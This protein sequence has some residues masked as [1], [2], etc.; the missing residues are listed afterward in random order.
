MPTLQSMLVYDGAFH[1]V[2]LIHNA[3]PELTTH[4]S[5]ILYVKAHHE[6]LAKRFI[7][8]V[9]VRLVFDVTGE[10]IERVEVVDDTGSL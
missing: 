10:R 3:D 4:A 8:R 7:H 9:L 6:D 1:R 5:R 2:P